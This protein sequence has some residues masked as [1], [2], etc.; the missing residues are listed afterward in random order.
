MHTTMTVS[1]NLPLNCGHHPQAYLD[2]VVQAQTYQRSMGNAMAASSLANLASMVGQSIQE[3]P[4]LRRGSSAL[5]N[6]RRLA[7]SSVRVI[8]IAIIKT[9]AV[10]SSGD[11]DR[12]HGNCITKPDHARRKVGAL[13]RRHAM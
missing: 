11:E 7:A 12:S 10:N 1:I 6:A 2:A 4:K 9:L 5:N 3:D 13:F 8:S